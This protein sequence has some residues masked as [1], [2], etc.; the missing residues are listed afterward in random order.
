MSLALQ[1]SNKTLL[2]HD[3]A[4]LHTSVKTQEAIMKFVWTVLLHP[5]YSPN[6]AP[7][8]FHPFGA[9][10]DALCTMKF[11]TDDNVICTVRSWLH[12]Q[13]KA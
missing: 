5:P 12:K 10:K 8:D 2:Q 4:R 11:E 9:L 13:D 6:L 7:A 3:S 1:D